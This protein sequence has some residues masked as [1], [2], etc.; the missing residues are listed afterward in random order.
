MSHGTS[1]IFSVAPLLVACSTDG[2]TSSGRKFKLSSFKIS[3]LSCFKNSASRGMN[4]ILIVS[5]FY[6]YCLIRA[7]ASTVFVYTARV[8]QCYVFWTYVLNSGL[9]FLMVRN[10]KCCFSS[11]MVTWHSSERVNI[12]FF[13]LS[14][15]SMSYDKII[16]HIKKNLQKRKRF[17]DGK[18]TK[19]TTLVYL[20]SPYQIILPM[21]VPYQ[22]L[23]CIFPL[24]RSVWC[25]FI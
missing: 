20:V 4:L 14:A 22:I 5:Q 10:S 21:R 13:C 2:F 1:R 17:S 7:L 23:F 11:E 25:R 3:S 16:I 18:A 6:R 19:T 8:I 12:T 9:N 24:T 15:K